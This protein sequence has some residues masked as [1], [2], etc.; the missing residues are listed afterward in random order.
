[1]GNYLDHQVECPL[2]CDHPGCFIT[3]PTD[4]ATCDD[5]HP[6]R[7]AEIARL[8]AEQERR[9][10]DRKARYQKRQRRAAT[11]PARRELKAAYN[12]PLTIH[13]VLGLSVRQFKALEMVADDMSRLG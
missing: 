2:L 11:G 13:E 3:T 4:I 6:L 10:V 8:E 12:R 9:A 5:H 1:M 7:L